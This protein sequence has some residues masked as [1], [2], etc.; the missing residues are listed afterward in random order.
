MCWWSLL[1]CQWCSLIIDGSCDSCNWNLT[2]FDRTKFATQLRP[3]NR[4]ANRFSFFINCQHV[5]CEVYR[6]VRCRDEDL[7][8]AL[9][10]LATYQTHHHRERISCF[11]WCDIFSTPLWQ[12]RSDRRSKN[13]VKPLTFFSRW[14]NISKQIILHSERK[15]EEARRRWRKKREEK[16]FKLIHTNSSSQLSFNLR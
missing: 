6:G 8:R 10:K 16:K 14:K 12:Q 2:N 9:N 3:S 11:L 5:M 4:H 1:T 7:V 15:W 13:F